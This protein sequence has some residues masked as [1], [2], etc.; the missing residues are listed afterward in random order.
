MT[1][2]ARQ[3]ERRLRYCLASFGYAFVRPFIHIL[4]H[5][6]TDAG[7][8]AGGLIFPAVQHCIYHAR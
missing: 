8:S 4:V 6:L 7:P 3:V 5:S 2:R 1:T